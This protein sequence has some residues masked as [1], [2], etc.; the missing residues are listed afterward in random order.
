MNNINKKTIETLCFLIYVLKKQHQ[1]D[2]AVDSILM[3]AMIKDCLKRVDFDFVK[4][5]FMRY[6]EI[7]KSTKTSKSYIANLQKILIEFLTDEIR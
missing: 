3:L 1:K 4:Q 7:K 5:N 6:I 2:I